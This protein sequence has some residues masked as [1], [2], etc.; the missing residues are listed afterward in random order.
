MGIWVVVMEAVAGDDPNTIEPEDLDALA[1]ELGECYPQV[2]GGPA[3]Y[4][5][6]LWV[7]ESN[8]GG[9]VMHAL[10]VWQAAVRELGMPTWDVVR[11]EARDAYAIEAGLIE[12]N[13][14]DEG[15]L[16]GELDEEELDQDE[17]DEDGD[18]EDEDAVEVLDDESDLDIGTHDY[19]LDGDELDGDELDGDDDELDVEDDDEEVT[20]RPV[21]ASARSGGGPRRSPTGAPRARASATKRAGRRVP[22][23]KPAGKKTPADKGVGA[24]KAAKKTRATAAPRPKKA[25]VKLA[26]V[27][28]RTRAKKAGGRIAKRR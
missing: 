12:W 21:R 24:K 19:E 8:A 7:E 18:E 17:L 27:G 5:A 25:A 1:E 6:E 2:S 28:A 23:G 10:R 11:A 26:P 4:Q 3:F 15:D 16:A 9:A 13:P 20:L 14:P 22:T